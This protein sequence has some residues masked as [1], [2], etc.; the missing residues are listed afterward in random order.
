MPVMLYPYWVEQIDEGGKINIWTKVTVPANSTLSLYI[1]KGNSTEPDGNNVFVFFDD[2]TGTNTNTNTNNGLDTNKWTLGGHSYGTPNYTVSDSLLKLSS[3]SVWSVIH[4][5]LTF[6]SNFIVECKARLLGIEQSTR[7]IGIIDSQTFDSYKFCFK[8]DGSLNIGNYIQMWFTDGTQHHIDPT[9]Y[10]VK[11][12]FHKYRIIKGEDA[13]IGQILDKYENVIVGHKYTTNNPNWTTLNWYIYALVY[14]DIGIEYD[15]IYIRKYTQHEPFVIT[16]QVN[17]DVMYV[18]IT[19]PNNNQ[20][21]DYQVAIPGN[22]FIST[23]NESLYILD[24]DGLQASESLVG[25]DLTN[26]VQVDPQITF[27]KRVKL[28][29]TKNLPEQ[30]TDV[31]LHIPPQLS[32]F[33]EHRGKNLVLTDKNNNVLSFKITSESLNELYGIVYGLSNYTIYDTFYLYFDDGLARSQYGLVPKAECPYDA[34]YKLVPRLESTGVILKFPFMP[35]HE[36]DPDNICIFDSSRKLRYLFDTY[37]KELFVKLP[38]LLTST[39]LTLYIY[40][41]DLPNDDLGPLDTVIYPCQVKQLQIETK[42]DTF[43]GD[44]LAINGIVY[45]TLQKWVEDNPKLGIF[46]IEEAPDVIS[47]YGS[48]GKIYKAI[49]HIANLLELKRLERDL[50]NETVQVTWDDEKFIAVPTQ[51][52]N[53]MILSGDD[54]YYLVEIALHRVKDI[55]I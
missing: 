49:L 34:E 32:T 16:Y 30:S 27:K 47:R 10:D 51:Y 14:D 39:G 20:L 12:D 8:E 54:K 13:V 44:I 11:N 25:E 42:Q 33:W 48:F 15:Y 28:Y 26:L 41:K 19:N 38:Y 7:I 35:S 24:E 46:S 9:Y 3:N 4:S 29:L 5:T 40:P 21:T 17:N 50:Q 23:P 1:V 43:I 52:R 6:S 55:R 37:N 18:A 36:F 31:I 53:Q 2:F 45:V 22:G